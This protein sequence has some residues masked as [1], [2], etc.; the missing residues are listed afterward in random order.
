MLAMSERNAAPPRSASSHARP[1][2]PGSSLGQER[3]QD[4]LAVGLAD[5]P[6]AHRGRDEIGD[7]RQRRRP[8]ALA[9]SGSAMARR[10]GGDRNRIGDRLA[11][12]SRGAASGSQSQ[13]AR[14]AATKRRALRRRLEA[15]F[16]RRRERDG[17]RVALDQ[18]RPVAARPRSG[19]RARTGW[20][21]RAARRRSR[22][23]ASQPPSERASTDV[24]GLDRPFE[25]V[26][27]GEGA[28][29]KR[30]RKPEKSGMQGTGSASAAPGHGR[31]VGGRDRA[32]GHVMVVMRDRG[33]DACP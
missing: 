22:R 7:Q 25:P 24:S 21:P 12:R 23:S 11:S 20:R 14:A 17:Q 5:R 18:R 2:A 28:D 31:G 16:R 13:A 6:E 15:P 19:T 8:G 30:R 4:L 9:S 1:R 29:R 26:R 3:G 10:R 27:I 32:R 33:R